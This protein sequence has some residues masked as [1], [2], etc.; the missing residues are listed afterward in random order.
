MS[1]VLLIQGILLLFC[2]GALWQNNRVYRARRKVIDEISILSRADIDAGKDWTWR[3]DLY[4][5]ISYEKQLLMFWK[6]IRSHWDK[7]MWEVKK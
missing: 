1:I 6:P 5:E 4:Q 7:K 3:H 2:L